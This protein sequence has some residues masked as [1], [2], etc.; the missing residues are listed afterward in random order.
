MWGD[1]NLLHYEFTES[2]EA[3]LEN[4]SPPDQFRSNLQRASER[5]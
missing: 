1:I 5:G 4:V 2:V 3:E